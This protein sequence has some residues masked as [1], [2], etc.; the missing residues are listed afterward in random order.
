[1]KK[2]AL[3]TGAS[4]GIGK[5]TAVEL[6]KNGFTVYAAA[7][8]LDRMKDIAK[9][10]IIP[11]L[12]DLTDDD[13]IKACIDYI[14]KREDRIDVPVNNAGYDSYGAIEDVPMED[15]ASLM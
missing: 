14:I 5:S 7:R 8:R 13:S 6:N 12:L 4:S 11:V 15:S 9:D 2:I 10:G 3:V 1:M